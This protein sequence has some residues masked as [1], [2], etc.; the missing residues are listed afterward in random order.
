[1]LKFT[2]VFE[3]YLLACQFPLT[4]GDSDSIRVPKGGLYSIK[5]RSLATP[6]QSQL[7]PHASS[8]EA[9]I[10]KHQIPPRKM[11]RLALMAWLKAQS[12]GS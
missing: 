8:F 5:Y 6:S 9:P 3:S 7:G 11:A 4:L 10:V 12:R 1:M 2:G